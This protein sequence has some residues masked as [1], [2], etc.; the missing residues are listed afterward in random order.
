MAAHA[1]ATRAA[2]STLNRTK[3]KY[4]SCTVW[5]VRFWR[6]SATATL[7]VASGS[8]VQGTRLRV[9]LATRRM[10]RETRSSSRPSTSSMVGGGGGEVRRQ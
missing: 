4:T 5:L 2:C 8:A 9:C 10:A 1:M 3:G 7:A 6:T